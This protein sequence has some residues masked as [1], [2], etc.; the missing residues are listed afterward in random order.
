M[1][2]LY[3]LI[4]DNNISNLIRVSVIKLLSLIIEFDYGIKG[5]LQ[6]NDVSNITFYKQKCNMKQENN[7]NNKE[8]DDNDIEMK[9]NINVNSIQLTGLQIIVELST[10]CDKE[11][12]VEAI[13]PIFQQV[14][15]YR[16][17][18]DFCEWNE[19]NSTNLI[20]PMID[21]KY[22]QKS[23]YLLQNIGNMLDE[24]LA[25]CM[26]EDIYESE[27]RLLF[28]TTKSDPC[29]LL[30][31][32]SNLESWHIRYFKQFKIIP[33]LNNY[34]SILESKI[35]K[36]QSPKENI[37]SCDDSNNNNNNN[38]DDDE[39]KESFTYA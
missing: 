32:T 38:D 30:P 1:L 21:G 8:A 26:C 20:L 34:L 39:K 11:D 13:K 24:Y 27:T 9:E 15:T 17:L 18:H 5:F 37:I 25:D 7:N 3:D 35:E 29:C 14:S 6:M 23:L 12:I 36:L 2:I 28:N 19:K 31:K 16:K 33:T 10:F 22:W 4:L